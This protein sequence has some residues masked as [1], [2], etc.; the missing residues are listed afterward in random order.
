MKDLLIFIQFLIFKCKNTK[1]GIIGVEKNEKN[2]LPKCHRRP[3]SV[4]K[5]I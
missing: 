5:L 4:R 2:R 1:T 3:T